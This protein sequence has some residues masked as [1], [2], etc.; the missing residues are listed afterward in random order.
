MTPVGL[1]VGGRE[2]GEVTVMVALLRGINVG[3]RGK[4]PM[5]DLRAIATDLGYD[6][7]ATYIQSGNLVLSSRESAASVARDLAKAI[8]AA[9]HVSPAV[10]IRTRTQLAKLVRDNPFLTRGEDA[11]LQHVLFTEGPAKAALAGLDLRSYAPEEA[12][13]VGHELYLF[14][15]NGVGRS[16]LAVD[17]GRQKVV[18]TMRS[19]R[20]VTTVLA[21][22]D[23]AAG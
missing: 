1:V 6:D 12:I 9:G 17:V 10:M 3:G 22:A 2:T 20:T 7:V 18:G 21:M 19:W 4:L 13:A 14:L 8:A 5:A 23:E 15:P 11:G 16:K